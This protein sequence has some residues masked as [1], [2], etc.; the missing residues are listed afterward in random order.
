MLDVRSAAD[1]DLANLRQPVALLDGHEHGVEG[2]QRGERV[3]DGEGH[4]V[5]L[6]AVAVGVR[7]QR[8]HEDVPRDAYPEVDVVRSNAFNRFRCK[9]R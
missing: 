3:D 9:I 6:G 1:P 5:G 4:A 2:R 8:R 7:V